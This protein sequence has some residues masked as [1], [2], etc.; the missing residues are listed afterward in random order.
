MKTIFESTISFTSSSGIWV[1][2]DVGAAIVAVGSA[3]FTIASAVFVGTGEGVG[4]VVGKTVGVGVEIGTGVFELEDSAAS[5]EQPPS[6]NPVIVIPI[7]KIAVFISVRSFNSSFLSEKI[8][9][10][11][12]L[13]LIMLTFYHILYEFSSYSLIA[14]TGFILLALIAGNVLAMIP[15][16]DAM[17]KYLTAELQSTFTKFDKGTEFEIL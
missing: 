8:S 17:S 14:S 3:T 11:I 4:M 12:I 6:R 7:K 13:K 16:P 10:S 2:S 1:G 15:S 5:L 9:V